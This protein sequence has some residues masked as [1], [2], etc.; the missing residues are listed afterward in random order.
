MFRSLCPSDFR[1]RTSAILRMDSL[2]A[3]IDASWFGQ[4]ASGS[5]Y[6]TSPAQRTLR[7]P[8]PRP[9]TGWPECSGNG[10]RNGPEMVAGLLRKWWPEWSGTRKFVVSYPMELSG[11]LAFQP[12]V[13]LATERVV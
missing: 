9:E 4:E 1:R 11:K 5:S 2:D 8:R 10:G 6:P 13:L 7:L 3:A 12:D